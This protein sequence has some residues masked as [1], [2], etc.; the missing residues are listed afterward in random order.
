VGSKG[1]YWGQTST[2]SVF[3]VLHLHGQTLTRTE[4][5]KFEE[6]YYISLDKKHWPDG[7]Q[8]GELQKG[9]SQGR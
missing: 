2:P 4:F 5:S 7:M 1:Q 9:E 8:K 6:F 3:L